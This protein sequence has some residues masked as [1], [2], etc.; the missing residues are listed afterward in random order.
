MEQVLYYRGL[1]NRDM[2]ATADAPD[3]RSWFILSC[4]PNKERI[5]AAH[6]IARRFKCYLPTERKE[7]WYTVHSYRGKS[8]RQRQIDEP[9][10][11]G[12]VFI[13]FGF[14]VDGAK[15]HTIVG[16]PGV[17]NFRKFGDDYAILSDFDMQQIAMI[18]SEL[19][20]PAQHRVKFK[21][22]DRVRVQ[23]GPFDGQTMEF[24]GLDT[25]GRMA[26]LSSRLG[27]VRVATHQ[28]ESA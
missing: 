12:M 14:A 25:E 24:I 5:A 7:R 8:R 2:L 18:E 11:R 9:I 21:A 10:F 28:L 22:G 17:H 15:R 6:L 4:Q 3:G 20:Q 13:R 19:A 1:N 26:W 16:C 23:D 27:R